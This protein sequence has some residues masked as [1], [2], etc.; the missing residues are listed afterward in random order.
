MFM[1]LCIHDDIISSC[2]P[3]G[4]PFYG[5]LVAPF[6]VIYIM[7]WIIFILILVS[8]LRKKKNIG[9]ANSDKKAMIAKL[10]QQFIIALTLS[11]LFGLGW[12]IGFAATTSIPI[13]AISFTLQAIFIFLTGF[14]GLLIFIMHCMRSEDARKEWK[15]WVAIITCHRIDLVSRKKTKFT[16]Q[17]GT[18]GDFRNKRSTL[19][20][21][22]TDSGTL[23]KAVMKDMEGS[24]V[25]SS[26]SASAAFSNSTLEAIEEAEKKDLSL[27]P[28]ERDKYKLYPHHEGEDSAGHSGGSVSPIPDLFPCTDKKL[29]IRVPQDDDIEMTV[30]SPRSVISPKG[31]AKE[32]EKVQDKF[33]IFWVDGAANE[34]VV[35]ANI[36]TE[37]LSELPSS[38][39]FNIM[40]LNDE[41]PDLGA[42]I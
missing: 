15:V 11:L 1:Q 6:A 14:Q 4:E 22:G 28:E 39:P 41:G 21:A 29:L 5:G 8:L 35:I 30:L 37:E 19:S 27:K 16:S 13:A 33:N 24:S 32:E 12:G 7:N 31:L 18:S 26:K 20:T 9:K 42:D 10:K 17:S 2:R 25:Y 3:Y 34:D 40:L 23:K 36:S 38:P